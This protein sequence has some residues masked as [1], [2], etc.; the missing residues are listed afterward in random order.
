MGIDTG[1]RRMYAGFLVASLTP[2]QDRAVVLE[3]IRDNLPVPDTI[4]YDETGFVPVIRYTSGTMNYVRSIVLDRSGLDMVKVVYECENLT[5]S[6]MAL[7]FEPWLTFRRPYNIVKKENLHFVRKSNTAFIPKTDAGPDIPCEITLMAEAHGA[8]LHVRKNEGSACYTEGPHYTEDEKTGDE[9]VELRGACY[10]PYVLETVVPAGKTAEITI[11]CAVHRTDCAIPAASD[12]LKQQAYTAGEFLKTPVNEIRNSYLKDWYEIRRLAH[13]DDMRDKFTGR[14][15]LIAGLYDEMVISAPKFITVKSKTPYSTVMAGYPWFLDWGRD[16]MIAFTGLMLVTGQF[17][18][19]RDVLRAFARY[20]KNGMVP[21]VFPGSSDEKPQYNT[22]DASLWFFYAAD[23]YVKFSGDEKFVKD[24]LVPVLRQ[25]IGLY[26]RPKDKMLAAG[27]DEFCYGI[28]MDSD[29]LVHAGT[30]ESD[31]LTWMDVRID[32]VAVTPRH[33]CPVEIQALMYNALNVMAVYDGDDSSR[34]EKY[35]A[36]AAKLEHSAMLFYN[37]DK[38]CLYDYIEGEPGSHT[39]DAKVR[40]NQIW[41]VSLPYVMYPDRVCKEIV[42]TV[43]TELVTDLGIRSLSPWDADYLGRYEGNL[44]SRDRAYHNGTAW[45]FL[46]GHYIL[47]YLKVFGDRP[48]TKDYLCELLAPY[49]VH[50]REDGCIYGIAEV[51][52]GDSPKTGKG[53]YNQAWSVGCLLEGIYA[54]YK[55]W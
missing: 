9:G 20:V 17:D 43:R 42:N 55:V 35:R 39:F 28:Y 2:P 54:M 37:S 31:Q 1:L 12:S 50:S 33:D 26:S 53:C 21:N 15:G 40:P 52:D 48:E 25:I 16:T 47:A 13:C 30:D 6:D 5:D 41:A 14:Y 10:V 34:L 32:G 19:A 44:R 45:G 29:G 38:H 8:V 11:L 3:W 49:L 36:L 7:E 22:V 4:D 23:M 46:T 18:T 24:E 51:F 27:Q